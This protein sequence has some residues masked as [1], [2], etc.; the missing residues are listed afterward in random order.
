MYVLC[1]AMFAPGA[2]RDKSGVIQRLVHEEFLV[3]MFYGKICPT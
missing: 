3:R 1:L 2:V